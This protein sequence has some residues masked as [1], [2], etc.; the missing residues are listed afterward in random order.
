V[1]A[2]LVCNN[3]DVRVKCVLNGNTTTTDTFM[4]YQGH[5]SAGVNDPAPVTLTEAGSSSGTT[6]ADA[7]DFVPDSSLTSYVIT[8]RS[9]LTMDTAD[10]HLAFATLD[11][12]VLKDSSGNT[13]ST[14]WTHRTNTVTTGITLH[15]WIS[16]SVTGLTNGNTYTVNLS[17]KGW[18]PDGGTN[19]RILVSITG[20]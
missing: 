5:K 2:V 14:T 15:T 3:Y 18:D 20:S 10:T 4:V 8:A 13:I 11:Q 16:G 6:Y 9:S 19:S 7:L 17:G 12:P 1:V